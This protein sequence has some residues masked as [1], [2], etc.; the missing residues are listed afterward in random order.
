MSSAALGAVTAPRRAWRPRWLIGLVLPVALVVAWQ[1]AKSLGLVSYADIPA[2]STI[3]S[4]T[5]SLLSSGALV[6]NVGH[7]LLATLGG[8]LLGSAFGLALGLL[9]GLSARAWRYSMASVDVLRALPAITFVP[10]AVIVFSQTLR[11]EMLI[12]AWVAAWPLVVSTVDGVRS[13]SAIHRDL[14]RSL[15]LPRWRRLLAFSLPTALPNI[16][17]AMRLGLAAALVLAIVAEIVGNPAGIGYA[18]VQEQQSLRPAAMFS[19]ILVTGVLG[20]A[21]NKAFLTA[22]RY[23]P[24]A[25]PTARGGLRGR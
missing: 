8:W 25:A 5:G 14:A 19:Y 3:A 17:I 23:L 7:T 15:E 1:L 18:L 4:A 11:M 20:V 16:V 9:L 21:L 10:A 13:V 22:V 12:A 24:G 2:P 6:R